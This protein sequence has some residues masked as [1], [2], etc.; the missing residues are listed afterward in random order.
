MEQV[1]GRKGLVLV[2][3]FIYSSADRDRP[4]Y[5]FFA[6]FFNTFKEDLTVL[7]LDADNN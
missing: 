1:P 2:T 4:L 5:S 6:S 3:R 7:Q